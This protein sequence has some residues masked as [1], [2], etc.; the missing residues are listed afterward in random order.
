MRNEQGK[1]IGKG[2]HSFKGIV[3]FI[4]NAILS[5]YITTVIVSNIRKN[6]KV[7][8]KTAYKWIKKVKEYNVKLFDEDIKKFITEK[9]NFIDKLIQDELY[10]GKGDKWIILNCIDRQMKLLGL[11]RLKIEHS[12]KIEFQKIYTKEEK[13]EILDELKWIISRRKRIEAE[14]SEAMVGDVSSQN[15]QK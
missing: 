12:G 11:D 14:K 15:A 8:R 9:Y 7:S 6:F 2:C 3:E 4:S 13:E 10:E 5:G 1:I